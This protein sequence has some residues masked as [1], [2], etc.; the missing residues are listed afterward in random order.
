VQGFG[1]L[2]ANHSPS[3]TSDASFYFNVK[4][5]DVGS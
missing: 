2:D 3:A 4:T 5:A 1:V